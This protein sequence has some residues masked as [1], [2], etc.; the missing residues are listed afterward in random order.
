MSSLIIGL[1]GGI[2]SGK[3][4]VARLFADKGIVVVDADQ[5]ARQIVLPGTPAL[6]SIRQ[7]FGDQILLT[8]GSLDRAALREL[9]FNNAEEK[10][11]LES[12][13]HPLIFEEIAQ[14]LQS[15]PSP[16]AILESPL[17]VEAGQSAICQRIL[18]V[19]TT[20][21][22]QVKRAMQR[23]N[24]SRELIE[25]IMQSQATR[26]QRLEHANDV[27]DNTKNT[28][29]LL[30]QVTTLDQKYRELASG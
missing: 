25:A 22:Q 6:E 1:T 10:H 13:L 4:T 21:E 27:V 14:Q 9:I 28:E 30:E 19:D 16:Y 23:D 17:L 12:L 26:E 24:N 18:V 2:G 11:W 8:D 3:S 15:A 29:H 5:C 20:E 7:H